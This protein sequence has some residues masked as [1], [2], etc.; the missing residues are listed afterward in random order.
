MLSFQ[1]SAEEKRL[2]SLEKLIHRFLPSNM[3][4]EMRAKEAQSILLFASMLSKVRLH[5]D[6]YFINLNSLEN[7]HNLDAHFIVIHRKKLIHFRYFHARR[8]SSTHSREEMLTRTITSH[9]F[10]KHTGLWV[11]LCCCAIHKHIKELLSHYYYFVS[12]TGPME[13]PYGWSICY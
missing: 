4:P 9:S 2:L 5:S 13:A 7:L 3:P 11:H 10:K 6:L 8:T 1:D 12:I